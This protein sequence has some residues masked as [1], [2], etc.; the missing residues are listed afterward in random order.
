M[1]PDMA[2]HPQPIAFRLAG[3]AVA[4]PRRRVS[5]AEVD[6]LVGH[7]S[8]WVE[9]R[10][11]IA[12]RSW[13]SPDETSS[14][15]AAQA[16]QAALAEAAWESGSLDVIVGA[17]GVMEQPIPGTAVLVQRRLG[18]GSTGIPAFDVNATCLS[19]LL[20]LDVVLTGFAAGKWRRALITGADIAS[21]ALDF[22]N[23]EASAIFGDGAAAVVL[24]SDGPHELLALDLSTYGE[25]A[26]HCRLE[27][28]GTRL[29]PHD[30]LEG[31]L[32]RSKF[33]MDGVGVFKATARRFPAFLE[34]LLHRAGLDA[35]AL[36]TVVPHQAS[37]TALE[38]LK[39]S[40]PGGH[41]KTVDI[42]RDHG[43]QIAVSLPHALHVARM[44]GALRPARTS[45]LIGS[46]AGISLGGA[47][48]RW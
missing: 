41:R 11:G 9:K 29:R 35:A 40:I 28:G 8:G 3:S 22:R 42:F 17:C 5:S 31:F 27:A 32:A 37:A 16:A 48:V 19:F 13:A 26:E 1:T 38:H 24:E 44:Q 36:D 7:R 2:M 6:A 43:N 45:L 25:G 20:A 18:L 46:S 34:R 14:A 23:P 39:R 21:A 12:T 4:V 30:D 10:F 47:V 33:Q 15:L